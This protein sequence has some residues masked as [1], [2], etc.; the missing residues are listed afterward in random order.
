VEV[1]K[2]LRGQGY[3]MLGIRLDSGDLA[4]LSI[5]ARK[6]LDEAGFPSA[7]IIA[8]SELDE[9][10]IESLKSRGAEIAV[11][12]VGTKLITAYDQPALGGVYKLSAVRTFPG[13]WKYK[14]K[15]SDEPVKISN[16]GIQ[17]VRR[18]FSENENRMDLIY[19]V[20]NG[21]RG[22]SIAVD[23]WEPEKQKIIS[24]SQ[25]FNDL[26]VPV[27]RKG[28]RVYDPPSLQDIKRHANDNLSRF[29]PDIKRLDHP[30]PYPV[31]LEKSLY[32]LKKDL[33]HRLE[34]SV[35]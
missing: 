12:G 7:K 30:S 22:D 10:L 5:E 2:W 15:L 33:L 26:L 28:K 16:P 11:W 8:S 20:R 19:D 32:E 13:D 6:I 35:S 29:N 34:E 31:C 14:V 17:Q 4:A 1:G 3:E 24:E 23:L 27:F 18:Y 9:S 25:S 21:L